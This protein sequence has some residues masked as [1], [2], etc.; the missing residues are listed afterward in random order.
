[1]LG[2][3]D[4]CRICWELAGLSGRW[5]WWQSKIGGNRS[6]G[7]GRVV[8][9]GGGLTPGSWGDMA[10]FVHHGWWRHGFYL[11]HIFCW[12]CMR[13]GASGTP[14][15]FSKWSPKWLNRWYNHWNESQGTNLVTNLGSA[16]LILQWLFNHKIGEAVAVREGQW[17]VRE[18]LRQLAQLRY[19]E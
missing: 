19:P 1:M 13:Y 5:W 8:A 10:D 9:A 15:V 16:L 17:S 11:L 4:G 14:V 6:S 2:S 7:P 3:W 18:L 12:K